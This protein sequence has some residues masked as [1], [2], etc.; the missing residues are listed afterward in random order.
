M[1]SSLGD[2]WDGFCFD[3]VEEDGHMKYVIRL[4]NGD[5]LKIPVDDICEI[6]ETK[7]SYKI[8]DCA[9]IPFRRQ[10]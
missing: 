10:A 9:V 6:L 3:L 2:W 8:G 1:R 4:D 7:K 5:T